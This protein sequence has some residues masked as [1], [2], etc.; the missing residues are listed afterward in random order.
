MQQA[1]GNQAFPLLPQETDAYMFSACSEPCGQ[2]TGLG[3]A[4]RRGVSPR[5]I[6][7]S[8]DAAGA[9]WAARFPSSH[10]WSQPKI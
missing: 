1:H 9:T 7:R 5:R 3:V 8:R 4:V 10:G 2:R 6:I